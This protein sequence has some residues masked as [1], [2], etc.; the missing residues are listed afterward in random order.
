MN[1]RNEIWLKRLRGYPPFAMRDCKKAADLIER[2]AAAARGDASLKGS[3]FFN[4]PLRTMVE[5]V[6]R[7]RKAFG[8]GLKEA[9]TACEA[10]WMPGDVR[11]EP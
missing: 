8:C 1:D 11:D 4:L 2:Q 3:A 9:I 10:G 5:R 7:Y 6:K